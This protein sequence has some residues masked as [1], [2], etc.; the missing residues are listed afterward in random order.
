MVK[1]MEE[2]ADRYFDCN[3]RERVAFE[4]GIKLGALFH[5][6]VGAP[7]SSENLDVLERAIEKTT[8]RQ[9]FVKRAEVRIKPI[10]LKKRTD[11]VFH[12]Y[13][14]LSG[15]ML[16]AT[17]EVEYKG[18]KAKGRL[19]YIEELDYPLMYLESIG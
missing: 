13:T 19:R 9:A 10:G 1:N 16:D 17:V 18:V 8:E 14:T 4:L 5:Q 2:I 15:D 3:D 7:V 11:S 12:D 6:F